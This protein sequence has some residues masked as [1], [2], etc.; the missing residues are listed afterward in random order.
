MKKAAVPPI[1]CAVVLLALSVIAGAQQQKKIP[2]IGY[3]AFATLTT[4]TYR[5]DAF[6]Q[7]LRQL[8]YV[9]GKDFVIEYRWAEGEPDRLSALAAEL[10]R[11]KVDVIVTRGPAS[12]RAARAA[13]ATIPIVMTQHPDPV[14][15]GFVASLAHPGGNVTGL[16]SLAPETSGKQGP[17]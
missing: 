15:N 1:L 17:C 4:N 5:T 11:L 12:T 6:R 13:S 16:S 10:V 9:E 2:R 8:R 14:G 3:L 7:G